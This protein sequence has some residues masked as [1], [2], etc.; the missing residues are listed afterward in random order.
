MPGRVVESIGGDAETSLSRDEI[1]HHLQDGDAQ[2]RDRKGSSGLLSHLRS[3]WTVEPLSDDRTN[4]V[5]AVEF[6]FANPFYAALS[7]RA[8]PK[9]AEFMIKAFEQRVKTLLESN[10]DMIKASLAE[11]DGSRLKDR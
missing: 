5:L 10:P 2:M 8:A 1:S 3:T 6:A 9:V 4:V 11:L 7:G